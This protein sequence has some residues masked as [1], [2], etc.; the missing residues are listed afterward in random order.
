MY[1]EGKYVYTVKEEKEFLGQ[2]PFHSFG[3]EK[4]ERKRVFSAGLLLEKRPYISETTN[5]ERFGGPLQKIA[6]FRVICI[7][8]EIVTL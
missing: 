6:I 7:F 5:R 2:P 1:K 8:G 3:V 4:S